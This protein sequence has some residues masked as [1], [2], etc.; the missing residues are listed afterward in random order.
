MSAEDRNREIV[1]QNTKKLV[2][3]DFSK[4]EIEAIAKGAVKESEFLCKITTAQSFNQTSDYGYD[5]E[6]PKGFWQLCDYCK[7]IVEKGDFNKRLVLNYQNNDPDGD[8][9]FHC[10]ATPILQLQSTY[11]YWNLTFGV[12]NVQFTYSYDDNFVEIAITEV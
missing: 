12:V 8:A 2:V 4:K 6:T 1:E 5:E 9:S 3:P 10:L 11:I 7:E